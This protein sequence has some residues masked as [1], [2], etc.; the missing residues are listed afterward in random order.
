LPEPHANVMVQMPLGLKIELE[1]YC[2][3]QKIPVSGFIRKLVADEIGFSLPVIS[4]GRARKY[5]TVEERMAAQKERDKTRRTLTKLLLEKY[6]KGE[7]T[8]DDILGATT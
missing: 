3:D 8:I 7:I 5:A 6:A 2:E 1:K 4:I